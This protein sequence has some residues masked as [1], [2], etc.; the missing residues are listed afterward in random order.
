MHRLGRHA[1]LAAI[2]L[3]TTACQKTPEPSSTGHA[4]ARSSGA[5]TAP[6]P[7]PS[8]LAWDVPASWSSVPNPSPLRRATY[9]IP[10][11]S[12]D[13]DEAEMSVSQAKGSVDMNVARWK[14]QLTG[15]PAGFPKR[16]E[17]SVAGL[18]VTV[19]EHRGTYNTAKN[20]MPGAPTPSPKADWALLGAIVEIGAAPYF[21]KV[22][23]PEKT[24]TA[25]RTDFDKLV[26]SIRQ[27]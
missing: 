10:P 5:A 16:D 17:R 3:L 18:K 26:E 1:A 25:A 7:G 24:V 20:M 8:S 22:T 9:H 4:P 19:I 21:F 13:P 14:E 6:Q 11:A 2:G 23:G 12:G 15:G 27:K